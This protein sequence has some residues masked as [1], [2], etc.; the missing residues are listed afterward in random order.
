MP[1][2]FFP[3]GSGKDD[4]CLP[5]Y[6]SKVKRQASIYLI[7]R[8]RGS[9]MILAGLQKKTIEGA[10]NYLCKSNH[11]PRRPGFDCIFP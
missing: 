10:G 4:G 7:A 9:T 6:R 3:A 1:D 8:K 2:A 11:N 5:A